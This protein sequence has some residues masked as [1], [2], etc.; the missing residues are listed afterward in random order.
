MVALAILMPI[1]ASM[2]GVAGTQTLTVVIRGMALGQIGKNNTRWLV[3]RELAV[4]ALNGLFW[5]SVVAVAASLWFND[6]T[7]GYIIAAAMV[8]NLLTAALAG[9]VLPIALKSMN[10]DP[11]L[12]GSVLLTTVTDVVG[13]MSFLGL[14]TW[15]YM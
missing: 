2:G 4:S 14:A 9:S 6:I 10:I 7:L 12:A 11:A 8:I 5:A 15:F 3:N 1:V 13:F